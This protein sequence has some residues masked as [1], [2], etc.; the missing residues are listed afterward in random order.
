[1][2]NMGTQVVEELVVI[3]HVLIIQMIFVVE[4]MPIQFIEQIAI[5]INI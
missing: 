2:V 4:Q 5:V 3:C 1:M